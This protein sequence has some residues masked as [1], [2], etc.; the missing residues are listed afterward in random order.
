L[1]FVLLASTHDILPPLAHATWIYATWSYPAMKQNM[2]EKL[3]YDLGL[4]STTKT[5]ITG[6]RIDDHLHHMT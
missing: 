6:W 4:T 3:Q 2:V 1:K 5:S